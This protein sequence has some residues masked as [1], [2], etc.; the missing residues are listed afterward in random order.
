MTHRLIEFLQ[1]ERGSAAAEMA[2][3]TPMLVALL[4]GATELGT[5]FMA[6]HKVVK[7]VRDGARFAARQSFTEYPSCTPST[8]VRDNTRNV[9]RTGQV[10]T[11]GT[12]RL[13]YWTS[14]TTITVTAA[15]YTTNGAGTVTYDGIYHGMSGGAP[16]VTVAATVPY[17]P[18]FGSLGIKATLN[19]HAN[20]QATVTGI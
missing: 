12:P 19:L 13:P 9:T 5:Y 11:G 2:L 10:T 3:A 20:A 7:A 17:T 4:F 14:P 15:C 1:D 18:L 16:V 8:T 6:E